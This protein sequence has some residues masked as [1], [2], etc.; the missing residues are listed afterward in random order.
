M[1]F[2]QIEK[3]FLAIIVLSKGASE[4]NSRKRLWILCRKKYF[5]DD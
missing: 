4:I 2:H 5:Y 3:V 1:D